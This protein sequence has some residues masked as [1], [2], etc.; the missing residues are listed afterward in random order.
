M[1]FKALE[2]LNTK[3]WYRAVKVLYS[4]FFIVAL[5]VVVGIFTTA[6]ELK[7]LDIS[8]S[9][10]KCHLGN[11]KTL[12][13]KDVF[14]PA[15]LPSYIPYEFLKHNEYF[16]QIKNACEIRGIPVDSFINPQLSGKNL[17]FDGYSGLYSIS[18]AYKISFVQMLICII[19]VVVSFETIRRIFYY[20]LLGTFLPRKSD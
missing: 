1:D 8:N 9:V 3:I 14:G 20:I 17:S 16:E 10:I 19:L 4:V 2:V 15:E 13:I 18:E 7:V 6:D 11:N 12:L 5:L